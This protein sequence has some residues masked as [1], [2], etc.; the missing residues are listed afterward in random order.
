MLLGFVA[1]NLVLYQH[2]INLKLYHVGLY[3]PIIGLFYFFATRTVF[4]YEKVQ[5]KEAVEEIAERYPS[6][7]LTQA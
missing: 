7:S 5:L 1:F 2:G 3:T 4:R 6:I